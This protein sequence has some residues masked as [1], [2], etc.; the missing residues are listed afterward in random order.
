MKST[1]SSKKCLRVKSNN[2]KAMKR[3]NFCVCDTASESK[4]WK[5]IC[6]S[7]QELFSFPDKI[8]DKRASFTP[9]SLQK[10]FGSL[11]DMAAKV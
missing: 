7:E 10:C 3:R 5:N 4:R 2:L 9:F 1:E 11:R 6:A 8:I